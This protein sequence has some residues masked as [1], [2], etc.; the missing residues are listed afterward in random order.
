MATPV[1]LGQLSQTLMGLVDTLMVGRLGE[2]PLAAVGVATLLFSA[3]AMSIKAVDVAAQTFT[4]RRVGEGRDGEVGAVLATAVTVSLGCRARSS[5]WWA[6][7]GPT[8]LMSL[9]SRRSRGPRTGRGYLRLPLRRHAAPAVLLQ[10]KAVFD[11][12]G[13]TR[14]GMGVGIGMNLVNVAA[15]LGADLR[16]AGR[17]G[18]GRGRGGPG[19]HPE[20]RCWPAWSSWAS[21]C[22]RR[23]A[24]GSGSCAGPISSRG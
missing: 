8:C 22:G 21:C 10:V 24:S 11:G 13:W 9:V 18:H 17:P 19:Q 6:C 5:C 20:R 23:S 4:A 3:M 14:I 1:V 15:E 2:G 16:Q 7:S 12:I